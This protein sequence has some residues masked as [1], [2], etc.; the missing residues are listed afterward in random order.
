MKLDKPTID[1]LNNLSKIN[2]GL[3][4]KEGN[5]LMARAQSAPSPIVRVEFA[6]TSF[7][8][9]FAI[10]DIHKFLSV[11][12]LFDDPELG[13]TKTAVTIKS[14]KKSASIKYAAAAM[15][16]HPDYSKQKP[17][18]FTVDT[19][20]SLPDADF[21]QLINAVKVFG[22]DEVAI[23][24]SGGELIVS[25]RDSK[26]PGNDSYSVS[27]GET[28]HQFDFIVNSMFLQ[29]PVRNYNIS[30]SFRGLCEFQSANEDNTVQYWVTASDK[31]KFPKVNTNA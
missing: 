3:V 13:F 2:P 15:I 23:Q 11:I 20:F 22:C 21:K 25:T 5:V 4:F 31:S 7:P 14:G 26:N 28:D 1:I 30:L 29:M 9:D 17:L 19:T 24:G 8:Q 27:V 16:S 18:N 12:A 6:K 10:Y